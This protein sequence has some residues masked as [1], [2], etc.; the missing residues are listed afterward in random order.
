[1]RQA[2]VHLRSPYLCN[3]DVVVASALADWL[4]ATAGGTASETQADA[5]ADA[6]LGAFGI[7]RAGS[8]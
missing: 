2:A 6:L 5:V 4:D 8:T 1:M 3:W 7:D